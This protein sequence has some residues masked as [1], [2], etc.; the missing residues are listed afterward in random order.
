V[1]AAAASLGLNEETV[2]VALRRMAA[3][4]PEAVSDFDLELASP[5]QLEAV[6]LEAQ[7]MLGALRPAGEAS[8][9]EP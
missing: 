3:A 8:R 6:L 7:R 2:V 1:G 9:S 5:A 4:L